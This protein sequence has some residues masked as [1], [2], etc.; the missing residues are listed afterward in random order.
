MIII[1]IIIIRIIIIIIIIISRFFAGNLYLTPGVP[2][3]HLDLPRYH[4]KVWGW[5]LIYCYTRDSGWESPGHEAGHTQLNGPGYRFN[6]PN[7]RGVKV[8]L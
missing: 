2:N 6:L 1:I 8:Q 5:T 7:S 3:P 4:H